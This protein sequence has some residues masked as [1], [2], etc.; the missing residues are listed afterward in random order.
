MT[1]AKAAIDALIHAFFHAFASPETVPGIQELFIPD[2]MIVKNL[3]AEPVVY[4]VPEFITPRAELLASGRLTGFTE[5]ETSERTEIWGN[6]AQRWSSYRKSGTLDGEPF[7]G[8]GCKS[9]QFVNTPD[10]WR[11]ASLIWDDAP[12]P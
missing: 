6:I 10:G 11:F 9:S 2:G 4:S 5:A 7:T 8:G 3:A 1:D 12:T